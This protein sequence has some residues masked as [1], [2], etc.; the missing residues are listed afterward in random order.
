MPVPSIRPHPA[1]K[2]PLVQC[3]ERELHPVQGAPP[4]AAPGAGAPPGAAP[5]AGAPPGAAPGA[6]APPGAAPGAAAAPSGA[7]AEAFG[8]AAGGAGPGFG[9]GLGATGDLFTMI[10]DQ[11]PIF[12]RP[13]PPPPLPHQ[14]GIPQPVSGLLA[15]KGGT[16]IPWVRG[17]KIA[18]N[19]SPKP[20]DRV[21]FS[22][23]YYNN[24]NYAID[25][26]FN[27]PVSGIQI[28][29]YQLGFEKTFLNGKASIGLRD[30]LNNL[31]ARSQTPGLGGTH[32]AMG[33]L[34]LFTKFVLFEKWEENRGGPAFQG[35]GS[36]A[37][38]GGRN[39]GLISGGLSITMPT[40][41]GSFA[42]APFSKSF[43]N[44]RLQPFLGYFYSRGNFYLHGFEAIDVP[45]D[46]HDVTELFNDVG[47]GYYLYRDPTLNSIITAFAPTFEVHV[48]VPL[49]HR[50]IFNVKDL[51]GTA[52]IVDLTYGGNI[53]IGRRA[54]VLLGAVSPVTG[55]R[56]FTIEAV[57]YLNV[58]FG[59][60]RT[61]PVSPAFPMAGQ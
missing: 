35:F 61:R 59:G 11:P 55:P 52:D 58:F 37:Q 19:Q 34:N 50:D 21:F 10:G 56:P 3:L 2:P 36:P 25:R 47:I 39:G 17:F 27:A 1:R 42:G 18:D 9:G 32:T 8:A 6:G 38:V 15:L 24:I 14:P 49:N 30:S 23:N 45:L 13:T 7:A 51:A 31:S 22:F 48:N 41:P 54:V 16:T 26:R 12:G 33:D 60:G 53:Q 28:Y 43:R 40:G 44:T 29:R 5:G 4:G 57:A 20:Q 46:P